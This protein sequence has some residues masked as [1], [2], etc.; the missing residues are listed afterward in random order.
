MSLSRAC[1]HFPR[2]IISISYLL[3]HNYNL[4]KQLRWQMTEWMS[5]L[6][7]VSSCAQASFPKSLDFLLQQSLGGEGSLEKLPKLTSG[8]VENVDLCHP[9]RPALISWVSQTP[10][11][12]PNSSCCRNLVG[13]RLKNH[14]IWNKS[15]P[16]QIQ[17]VIYSSGV[18]VSN[19][20]Q[21]GECKRWKVE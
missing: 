17:H 5:S 13:V 14:G 2:G 21:Q 16:S 8:W 7:F 18:C 10:I 3:P 9:V 15:S 11:F 20:A 12:I 6:W 19:S 1:P 4:G